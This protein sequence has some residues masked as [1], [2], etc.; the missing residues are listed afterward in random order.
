MRGRSTFFTAFGIALVV[1]GMLGAAF[2]SP[3]LYRL[4]CSVTGYG[5]TPQTGLAEP[6]RAVPTSSITVRFNAEA[7]P[8]L[9]WAF[10]PDQASVKVPLGSE[11]IAFYRAQNVGTQSMTGIAVYN[12][13]PDRVGR[14]FHKTACFCFNEQ[15]L[16]PGQKMEFPLTFWVDPAIAGDPDTKDVHTITLNYTFFHSLADAQA[17]GALAHA[18]PHV[19]P[20]KT[21][22]TQ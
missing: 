2:A 3:A 4:F 17:A 7:A 14:F 8:N 5:G 22:V 13:T 6:V 9:P 16:A 19:G 11:Q 20:L 21:A 10:Q 1:C 18:G 12:V 15:V